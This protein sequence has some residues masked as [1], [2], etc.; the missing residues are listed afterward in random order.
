M[1]VVFPSLVFV[2][3]LLSDYLV[4]EQEEKMIVVDQRVEYE[5]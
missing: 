4:H 3:V 2:S 5:F 1:N